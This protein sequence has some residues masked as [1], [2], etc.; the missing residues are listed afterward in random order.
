VIAASAD[1]IALYEKTKLFNIKSVHPDGT[2]FTSIENAKHYMAKGSKKHL[3]PSQNIADSWL[4]HSPITFSEKSLEAVSQCAIKQD[5]F[6]SYSCE[7]PIASLQQL[8][9]TNYEFV[10]KLDNDAKIG[11][12]E[13][14]FK[15]DISRTNLVAFVRDI[16]NKIKNR[17]APQ[18]VPAP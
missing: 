13:V 4:R 5:F 16:Y 18:V 17:Y 9:G 14:S 12:L 15:K 8:A 1:E 7:I 10:M 2:V 6:G 3:L 11:S